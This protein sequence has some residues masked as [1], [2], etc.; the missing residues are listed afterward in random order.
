MDSIAGEL[1]VRCGVFAVACLAVLALVARPCLADTFTITWLDDAG[2]TIG[3]TEVASGVVPSHAALPDKIENGLRFK[4]AGWTPEPVAAT[5]DATY[6]A[7]FEISFDDD[8][9]PSAS[10]VFTVTWLDYDGSILDVME[11]AAGEVPT[12]AA[13]SRADT[14]G[15]R[16]RFTGWIPEPSAAITNASYMAAFSPVEGDG[17][18][19]GGGME[20][21]VTMFDMD[22]AP[23]ITR[24]ERAD[25]SN[26]IWTIAC[27]AKLASG[28]ADGIDFSK[29]K[30][31]VATDAREVDSAVASNED[32][33]N[34]AA[35][36][37]VR[38]T[39]DVKVR[40]PPQKMYFFQ[41]VLDE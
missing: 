16:W 6:M 41:V 34:L 19:A 11:V 3:T 27:L 21:V 15:V 31:K 36:D 25:E 17:S 1:V 39:F 10:N 7:S 13:V 5:D 32:I 8:A 35:E 9:E 30:V 24:F 37:A 33:V 26:N 4:F 20:P 38:L 28:T 29:V 14:N 2:E 12:H 22:F 23:I 18:G 40:N